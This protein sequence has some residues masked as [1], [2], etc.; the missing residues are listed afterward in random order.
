MARHLA[1]QLAMIAFATAAID[2]AMDGLAFSDT[3]HVALKTAAGFYFLGLLLGEVARRLAEENSERILERELE[4]S[5]KDKTEEL[6]E[7]TDEKFEN[8]QQRVE[9]EVLHAA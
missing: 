9:Q 2:G 7:P 4:K 3:I 5:A 1:A 8:E 6:E